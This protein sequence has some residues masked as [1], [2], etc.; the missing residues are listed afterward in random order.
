[1]APMFVTC[2][3]CA[4]A[5]KVSETACPHCGILLRKPDGSVGRTAAA[6]LLGL[7][8]V[9]VA[10]GDDTSGAGGAGGDGGSSDGG[11]AP[12]YGVAGVG[13]AGT[14]GGAGG[15]DGGNAPEYGVAGVGG[16]GGN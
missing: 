10:C 5:A 1:M 12:E 8:S 3:E 14:T 16:A 2:P 6:I 11:A 15:S 13:G 7:A 4:C 9:A